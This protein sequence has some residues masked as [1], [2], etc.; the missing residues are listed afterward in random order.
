VKPKRVMEVPVCSLEGMH[1]FPGQIECPRCQKLTRA[2]TVRTNIWQGERLIVV[3]DI[4]AQ[5]CEQCQEQY[6][7]SLTQEA[8]RV[9]VQDELA[10]VKP[11][12]VMEVTVYSLEGRIP[13]PPP[14]ALEEG[15]PEPEF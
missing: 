10:S 8:L 15:E 4:P 12:R 11:K 13:E 1:E 6:Y 3:E 9:L 5:I 14:G 7:D 2:A